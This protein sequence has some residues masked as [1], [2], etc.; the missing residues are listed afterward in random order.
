VHAS[1]DTPVSVP[2][3]V[4]GFKAEPQKNKYGKDYKPPGS[5]SEDERY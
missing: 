2:I 1:G 5:E 3:D 4:T